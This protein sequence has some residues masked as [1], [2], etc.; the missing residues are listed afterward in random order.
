MICRLRFVRVRR[1]LNEAVTWL[2]YPTLRLLTT[3]GETGNGSLP[4]YGGGTLNSGQNFG[5]SQRFQQPHTNHQQ[6]IIKIK[7]PESIENHLLSKPRIRLLLN[8]ALGGWG[9]QSN[10]THFV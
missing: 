3:R 10:I 7:N 9:T 6:Q 4:K 5:N 2:G 1:F 8:S